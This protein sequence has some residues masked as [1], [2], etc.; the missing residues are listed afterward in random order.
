MADSEIR[1]LRVIFLLASALSTAH[2]QFAVAEQPSDISKVAQLAQAIRQGD[3][4]GAIDLARELDE[5]SSPDTD[6]TLPLARLART[7][8]QGDRIE[9]SALF[10]ARAVAASLRPAAAD[11]PQKTQV[12]LRLAAGGVLAKSSH[13]QAAVSTV[14]PLLTA[15]FESVTEEQ[16]K[17]AVSVCLSAGSIALSQTELSAAEEAYDLAL[18]HCGEADRPTALLGEAWIAV[19]KRDQPRQA[20]D[21]LAEFCRLFPAHHDTPGAVRTCIE[22]CRHCDDS[23]RSSALPDSVQSWLVQKAIA[24]DLET[25]DPILSVSAIL[26]ASERNEQAAWSNLVNHLSGLESGGQEVSD[27]FSQLPE[28]ETERLAIAILSPR[29]TNSV[30]REAAAR[31]AARSNRWSLLASVA[32]S[33][34]PT[35]E[36]PSRT[37]TVE[38]LFAEALM[39]VGRVEES[40]PWWDHLVRLSIDGR[41]FHIAALRRSGNGSRLRYPIG[42][43][44]SRRC[45]RRR[46][47]KWISARASRFARRRASNSAD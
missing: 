37:V 12:I 40:K 8:E 29:G 10:Y 20:A 22:C 23:V 25:F 33:Q 16:R 21:K 11:L 44:T 15:V 43:K 38:R 17:R 39:Q 4:E 9:E 2:C 7:L 34:Q 32:E 30:A 5:S 31:W 19:L 13:Y 24:N 42:T 26:V 35:D 3:I 41:F 28:I 47:K 45:S 1:L 36:D 27:A 6:L 14:E 46:R 18:Q